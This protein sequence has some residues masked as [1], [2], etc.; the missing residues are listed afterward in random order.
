MLKNRVAAVFNCLIDSS[1]SEVDKLN[2]FIMIKISLYKLLGSSK[3]VSKF[4]IMN[5]VMRPPLNKCLEI[6]CF[7]KDK[8]K[9]DF[10]N[11]SHIE[12]YECLID[13]SERL[14]ELSNPSKFNLLPKVF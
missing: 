5:T 4:M 3:H 7:Y 11:M 10:N 6:E 13:Y 9:P 2:S 12:I 14:W 1:Q 8:T